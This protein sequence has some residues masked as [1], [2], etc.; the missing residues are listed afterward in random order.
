MFQAQELVAIVHQLPGILQQR[1][2][3]ADFEKELSASQVSL[4][5]LRDY[6]VQKQIAQQLHVVDRVRAGGHGG[7]RG[8][9]GARARLN[10]RRELIELQID[11]IEL[12]GAE[13]A[14]LDRRTDC[15][16]ERRR[17]FS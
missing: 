14:F 12:A 15:G 17:V 13:W 6:E 11:G 2:V 10:R 1:L 16:A 9:R 7:R 4:D 8:H 3:H 5:V